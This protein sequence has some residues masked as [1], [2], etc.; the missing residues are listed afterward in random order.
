M[1]STEQHLLEELRIDRGRARTPRAGLWLF[2]LIVVVL[3]VLGG[4]L[5]RRDN[6]IPLVRVATVQEAVGAGSSPVL[7]ASGY[8]TARRR[9]TVSSKVTGKVVEVTI[10]EGMTIPAGF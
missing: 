1:A 9:A 8:V 2:L 6:L 4:W 3:V 10:E 5:W 7:N